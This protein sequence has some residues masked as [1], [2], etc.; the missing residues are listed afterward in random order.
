[1]IRGLAM[2]FPE[3]EK[4][5][6]INDQY[7]WGSALLVNPVTQAG[8]TQR[9]VYLPENAD[10]YDLY[11]GKFYAGGQTIE[12]DA[13]YGRMPVFVRS[14]S[15]LPI[16]RDLQYTNERPQDEL[17]LYVY[18]GAD[19]FFELYEDEGDNY[20]Y[21]NGNYSTIAIRYDH[22]DGRLSIGKTVGAFD[23]MPKKRIFHVVLVSKQNAKGIDASLGK[24]KTVSY[25]GKETSIKLK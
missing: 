4:T 6:A 21:E 17:T 2:D 16:G 15:I 10:W 9:A 11:Q 22:V 1:M 20:N 13:P 12:A 8:V 19:A 18:D 14:G 5:Y 7:L 24:K 25:N 23:G 3:D